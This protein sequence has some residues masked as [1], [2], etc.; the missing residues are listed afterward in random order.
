[1]HSKQVVHYIDLIRCEVG[2]R[3]TLIPVDH[4]SNLVVNGERSITS[5]VL[6]YD[7]ETG[8]IETMNTIYKPVRSE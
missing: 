6:S 1:M 4:P 3:A 5:M 7:R 8:I 2:L